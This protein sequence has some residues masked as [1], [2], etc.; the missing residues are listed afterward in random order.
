MSYN[1]SG[2]VG[3][4]ERAGLTAARYPGENGP[5]WV[6]ASVYACLSDNSSSLCQTLCDGCSK[7]KRRDTGQFSD[8]KRYKLSTGPF[9][10]TEN[11][12]EQK[13]LSGITVLINNKIMSSRFLWRFIAP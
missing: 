6:H 10:F 12:E 7:R 8:I 11:E 4:T 2:Q 9:I 1:C 13:G 5:V 3:E